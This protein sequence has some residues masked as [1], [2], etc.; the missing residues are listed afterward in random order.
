MSELLTDEMIEAILRHMKYVTPGPW[1]TWAGR[2]W[3]YD[4][5]KELGFVA[6]P[7]FKVCWPLARADVLC[8]GEPDEYVGAMVKSADQSFVASA[9][10]WFEKALCELKQLRAIKQIALIELLKEQEEKI[11]ELQDKID[12]LTG[13]ISDMSS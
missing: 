6:K 11:A 4:W 2:G 12:D 13:Q 9:S 3:G 1:E 8:H 10:K 7:D 5:D